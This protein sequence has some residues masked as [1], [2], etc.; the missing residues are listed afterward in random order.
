[1]VRRGAPNFK[2][3]LDAVLA[4][5]W[6]GAEKNLTVPISINDWTRGK[7]TLVDDVVVFEGKPVP[8]ELNVRI[9]EMAAQGKSPDAVLSF[10]E[11]LRLNP[12]Y[13]SVQQLWKFLEHKGIPLAPDGCI[14]AYK[15]VN[16]DGTDCHTGKIDNMPGCVNEMDRKLVSDDPET[17]CH[18]GFHVGSLDY[19][20]GFGPRVVICKVDPGDVVSV[21]TDSSCQKMRV[22]KY[23]VVGEHGGQMDSLAV[24]ASDVP[25]IH[26]SP[27]VE[28]RA[29]RKP[30]TKAAPRKTS[31]FSRL[32]YEKLLAEK[33]DSLRAYAAHDLQI[34]GASKIPGGKVA[35]VIRIMKVRE[36][37]RKN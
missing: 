25:P 32:S 8:S 36:D 6:G 23:K 20:S 1:M 11:R 3:L 4:G 34:V 21:P 17:D 22:C 7:F 10:W 19:A 28:K 35:L 14:L 26:S 29:P 9:L 18:T 24:D 2:P 12:S 13:R 33:L 16:R 31:R 27:G 37:R 5:D 15:G 30:T